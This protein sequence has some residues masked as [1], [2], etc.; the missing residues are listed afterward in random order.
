[1]SQLCKVVGFYWILYVCVY[2]ASGY[3][4]LRAPGQILFTLALLTQRH[5]ASSLCSDF[6]S[7]ERKS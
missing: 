1:M 2:V 4:A 5:R 3:L 7:Q 6:L